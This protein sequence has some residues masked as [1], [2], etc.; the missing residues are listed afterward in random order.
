MSIKENSQH[1]IISCE[2]Y[3]YGATITKD[4]YIR[5]HLIKFGGK[6]SVCPYCDI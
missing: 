2:P 3:M 1:F 6:K 5:R 4:E